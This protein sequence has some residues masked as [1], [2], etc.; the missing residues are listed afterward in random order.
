MN[1]IDTLLHPTNSRELPGSIVSGSVMQNRD[2]AMVCCRFQHVLGS[3]LVF[4][5]SSLL[6]T[7]L[8][9]CLEA[10]MLNLPRGLF[11]LQGIDRQLACPFPFPSFPRVFKATA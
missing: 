4:S 9:V 10:E 6:W 2:E 3:G 1:G 11:A 8:L 7:Q 5:P